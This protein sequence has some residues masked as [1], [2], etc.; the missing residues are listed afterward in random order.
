MVGVHISGIGSMHAVF[1]ENASI[2]RQ[3]ITPLTRW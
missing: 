2:E 3:L 1:T